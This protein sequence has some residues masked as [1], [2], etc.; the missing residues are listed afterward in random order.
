M[1][2]R[3]IG[4]SVGTS[5]ALF[6]LAFAIPAAALAGSPGYVDGSFVSDYA[7]EDGTF[8]E[9]HLDEQLIELLAGPAST[10]DEAAGE[11]A[12]GLES[13]RAMVVELREGAG[14]EVLDEVRGLQARLVSDGWQNVARVRDGSDHVFVML[15]SEGQD[16]VGVTVLVV[17]ESELVFTN[18]AGRI[19]LDQLARLA[20][21]YEI[22][23][24]D[25]LPRSE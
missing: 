12:A 8:V 1:S 22:P 14:E 13:V 3:S 16:L 19:D 4:S 18:V 2:F 11:I 15:K 9:V 25:A 6:A 21:S 17:N 23:G 24:L 10:Y 20:E 7:R 5:A